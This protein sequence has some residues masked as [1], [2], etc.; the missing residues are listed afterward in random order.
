MTKA[1]KVYYY[2]SILIFS[3]WLIWLTNFLSYTKDYT[4]NAIMNSITFSLI[5]IFL[6]I[7]CIK[8]KAWLKW[9]LLVFMG[10]QLLPVPSLIKHMHVSLYYI[11]HFLQLACLIIASILLFFVKNKR[12]R[13]I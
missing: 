4:A 6:G 12:I 1:N 5:Y 10:Y 11:G 2:S 3:A 7:S 8:Q 9:G 13:S